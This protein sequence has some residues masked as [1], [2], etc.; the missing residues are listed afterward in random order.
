[1]WI[2]IHPDTDPNPS[3]QGNLDPVQDPGF[4]WQKTE[5][6][7]AETKKF[8]F[9]IKN[10]NYLIPRP[11]LRTSKLQEKPSAPKREHSALPKKCNLFSSLFVG[12]FCLPGSRSGPGLRIWIRFRG[13]RWILVVQSGFGST[14]LVVVSEGACVR[15]ENGLR[16]VL[17]K[18]VR[19]TSVHTPHLLQPLV[20]S[21][22]PTRSGNDVW[23]RARIFKLLWSPGIDSKE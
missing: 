3:F 14:T 20:S 18:I 1:M 13:P 8:L 23:C 11:P 5:K 17:H 22:I 10:C 16:K 4:W 21:I 15:L 6:N 7:T 9:L 19:T 12:H 2:R